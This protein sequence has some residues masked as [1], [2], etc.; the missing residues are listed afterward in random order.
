MSFLLRPAHRFVIARPFHS[1]A[2]RTPRTQIRAIGLSLS[3]TL[4]GT[5]LLLLHANQSPSTVTR[6]PPLSSLIRTYT[7]YTICSFPTLVDYS[8]SILRTLLSVPVVRD[9]T[10]WVVRGTFFAQVSSSKLMFT[11]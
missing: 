3:G 10:E 9:V 11:A 6:D 2:S 5:S 1:N 4:L 7:V 8:P